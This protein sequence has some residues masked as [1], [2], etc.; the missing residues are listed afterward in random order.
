MLRRALLALAGIVLF[1]TFCGL[2]V[3]QIER[4]AWKLALIEA[5]NERVAAAPSPAPGPGA[6]DGIGFAD[7]EYRHVSATGRFVAGDYAFVQATTDY[8]PGF[9]LMQPF[10]DQ[11][12]FTLLVDRGFVPSKTLPGNVAASGATAETVTGLLR[13]SQPGGAF[14]R[15]NVPA[16][17]RWYSRDV[18]AIAKSLQLDGPVAPYFVDEGSPLERPQL[19]NAEM[20][21]PPPESV[22]YPV[23]GLTQVAF[24][25]AHL[26]YAL[27]WFALAGLTLVAAAIVYRSERRRGG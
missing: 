9:W 24:R 2:G 27:T 13:V 19:P 7:D 5:V 6:W 10:R 3:W 12:G 14:L 16:E 26:Q 25:N 23:T 11:R 15:S 20:G 8:G 21:A 1:C 17:G 4:R 22:T 18:A